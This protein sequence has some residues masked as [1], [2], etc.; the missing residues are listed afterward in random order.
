MIKPAPVSRRVSS[1]RRR[2]L[3]SRGQPQASWSWQQPTAS[4]PGGRPQRLREGAGARRGVGAGGR[5]RTR[6]AQ[7]LLFLPPAQQ[8]QSSICWRPLRRTK[9]PSTSTPATIAMKEL[10][11]DLPCRCAVSPADRSAAF[12]ATDPYACMMPGL[13]PCGLVRGHECKLPPPRPNPA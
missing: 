8:A 13:F 4:A 10:P 6:S 5:D 11:L 7:A 2:V 1:R 12:G 3:A 9:S